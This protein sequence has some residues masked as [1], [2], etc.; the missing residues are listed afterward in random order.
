MS[1][2]QQIDRVIQIYFLKKYTRTFYKL[3]HLHSYGNFLLKDST[4]CNPKNFI[5]S[6]WS[7]PASGRES[8]EERAAGMSQSYSPTRNNG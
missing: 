8:G 7:T 1:R 6:I 2:R 4:R 5:T 3:A